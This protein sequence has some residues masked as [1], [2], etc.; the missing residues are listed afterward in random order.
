MGLF[1]GDRQYSGHQGTISVRM[2][3]DAA[4]SQPIQDNL[5]RAECDRA[6]SRHPRSLRS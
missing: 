4:S 6:P 3:V 5:S 1:G 2:S